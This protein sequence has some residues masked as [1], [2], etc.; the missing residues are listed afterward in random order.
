MEVMLRNGNVVN[1]IRF[2]VEVSRY[3]KGKM[4]TLNCVYSED[5]F[6]IQEGAM[7]VTD[8]CDQALDELET[9]EASLIETNNE[10]LLAAENNYKN[11]CEKILEVG[12]WEII[13]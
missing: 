6:T 13:Q 4:Y 11:I 1:A 3:S 12:K 7:L 9:L 2:Y 8:D 10:R 5:Y